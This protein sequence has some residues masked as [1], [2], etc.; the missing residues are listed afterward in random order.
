MV[1]PFSNIKPALTLQKYELTRHNAYDVKNP[2]KIRA[3]IS[4]F[5][6]FNQLCF[7]SAD[8]SDMNF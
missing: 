3:L 2:N 8:G 1:Y 4:S 6:R 7:H 5:S